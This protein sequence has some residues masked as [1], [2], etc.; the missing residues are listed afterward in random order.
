MRIAA[1]VSSP[2]ASVILPVY[3]AL[4]VFYIVAGWR[5]FAKAGEPGWGIFIPIYNLYLVCKI[6][7]RP[8]WWVIL[9]FIPLVNVVI[10][11]IIA[12]DVAKAFSKGPGFGIGLWLLNFIFVPIPGFG[13][14]QYSA[15]G[16]LR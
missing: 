4:F 14:A 6:S 13:S 3:L 1:A 2:L 8:E 5:V 10:G 15:P 11:L 12:M 7:G 16:S 9:F